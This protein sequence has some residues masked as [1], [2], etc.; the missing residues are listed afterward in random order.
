MSSP[1]KVNSSLDFGI[2]RE[3]SPPGRDA[4]SFNLDRRKNAHCERMSSSTPFLTP[5][6]IYVG[7][8]GK[9]LLVVCITVFLVSMISYDPSHSRP[10]SQGIFSNVCFPTVSKLIV[11]VHQH[12]GF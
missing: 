8:I 11:V 7:S 1:V 4:E 6:F 12:S 10:A 9:I 5:D 2:S 3:E